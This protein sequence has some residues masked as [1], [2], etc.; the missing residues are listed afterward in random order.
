MVLRCCKEI[1][2]GSNNFQQSLIAA[3]CKDQSE[4]KRRESSLIVTGLYED[5]HYSDTEQFQDFCFEEF[6]VQPAI[7]ST[8]RL[9]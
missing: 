4:S 2:K 5:Q 6:N 3:V 1:E 7:V 9:G 8:R